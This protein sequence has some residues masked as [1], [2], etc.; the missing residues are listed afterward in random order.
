MTT[1]TNEYAATELNLDDLKEASG[2]YV[3]DMGHSVGDGRYRSVDDFSGLPYAFS[4]DL[5]MVQQDAKSRGFFTEVITPE[6]YLQRFDSTYG[7]E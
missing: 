7:I 5:K 6:Q 4:D 2:G 3:V 1:T